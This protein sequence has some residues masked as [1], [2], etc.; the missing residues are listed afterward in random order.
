[1]VL[2]DLEIKVAMEKGEIIIENFE[3]Q[4]LQPASYD[5]RV[6]K[7]GIVTKSILL[8]EGGMVEGPTK[9]NKVKNPETEKSIT[10]PQGGFALL[11]SLEY[12]KLSPRYVA[13][14]G[15]RSFYARKGLALLSALQVDPGWQ[16]ILVLEFTNLSSR[17]ITL[18]YQDTVCTMEIYRLR[19]EPIR[20]Y[21]GILKEQKEIPKIDMDY[22]KTM[23][24]VSVSN[25]ME[26][27]V[28]LTHHIKALR[29]NFRLIS[30]LFLVL[31][32]AIVIIALK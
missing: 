16:G 22:L 28:R 18:N 29:R 6:G 11:T 5:L 32:I 27:V 24:V 1:M 30:L 26:T 12:I 13:H 21:A 19:K 25:L 31:A 14:V 23:E 7:Q 10:I 15:S 4:C 9:D 3:E 20:P 17:S 8:G 2:S